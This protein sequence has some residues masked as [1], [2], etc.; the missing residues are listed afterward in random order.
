MKRPFGFRAQVRAYIGFLEQKKLARMKALARYPRRG[1]ILFLGDSLTEEFPFADLL[2]GFDIV[3]R[4]YSGDTA[5]MLQE[6]LSYTCAPYAPRAVFL[7]VGINDLQRGSSPEEAAAA[8]AETLDAIRALCPAAKL[9]LLALYPVNVSAEK[10]AIFRPKA[11][12]RSEAL[13]LIGR[14]NA[15]LEEAAAAREAGFLDPGTALKDSGGELR[16]EFSCDGLHLTV[17][18]YAALAEGLRPSL[19]R[20]GQTKEFVEI[21]S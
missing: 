1:G 14:T 16:E 17:E 3:G 21:R 5:G 8:A 11:L 6:R 7:Q 2:P 20:C 15:L 10:F 9:H 13:A 18:G 4:G 19:V 12:V